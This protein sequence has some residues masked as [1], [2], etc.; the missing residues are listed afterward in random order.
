MYTCN[1]LEKMDTRELCVLDDAQPLRP[2]KASIPDGPDK[3][4]IKISF[5]VKILLT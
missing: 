1:Y 5:L 2:S 3:E 4:Y